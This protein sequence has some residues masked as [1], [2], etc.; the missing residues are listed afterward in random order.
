MSRDLIVGVDPGGTG[1][2][3][4]L[5]VRTGDLVDVHDMPAHGGI[6]SAP[7][8]A[9]LL[10]RMAFQYGRLVIAWVE[11]VHSMPKQGVASSFKFGRAFGTIIGVLGGARVPVEYVTPAVWKRTAGLKA[12]KGMSRRRAIELWPDHS[13]AFARVKDDG[14]AEAAL[15]A[16]HGWLLRTQGVAA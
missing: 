11:D 15:V 3:A 9:D 12:D 10:Q 13:T 16:R 8:A 5:D 2:I 1:A 7:L 14:R 4:F 6:V